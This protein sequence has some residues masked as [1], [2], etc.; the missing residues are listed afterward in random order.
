MMIEITEDKINVSKI[1]SV[2]NHPEAGGIDVFIG[3][4]RNNTSG[5]KVMRLEF[6][7]H[8]SMARKELQKI[9]NTAKSKWNIKSVAIS[10]RIGVVNI[11]DESVIIAVACSHRNDAFE[12]CRF[13]IDNLK[14]NVPIWKKEIFENSEI[15]VASYS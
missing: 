12:S 10:H 6:E 3:T 2:V 8:V 14:K 11:G 9:V 15:W 7:S 1:I 13:I 5:K 4:A